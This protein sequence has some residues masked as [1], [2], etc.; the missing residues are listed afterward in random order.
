MVGIPLRDLFIQVSFHHLAYLSTD[1]HHGEKGTIWQKPLVLFLFVE[2]T[3]FFFS[4]FYCK[5]RNS[6]SM[7]YAILLR[8]CHGNSKI[9]TF[10]GFH[11]WFVCKNTKWNKMLEN[12]NFISRL[13]SA[14]QSQSQLFILCFLNIVF[15]YTVFILT[16]LSNRLGLFDYMGNS[17]ATT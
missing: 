15:L 6:T 17:I 11:T 14:L 5:T 1:W 3:V 8:C 2:K 16:F 9:V 7:L 4:F 12:Y 13:H 10:F